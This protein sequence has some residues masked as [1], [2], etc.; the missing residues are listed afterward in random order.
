MITEARIL[1]LNIVGS[2]WRARVN[3]T[4]LLAFLNLTKLQLLSRS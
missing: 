3:K 1:G 4:E 2:T